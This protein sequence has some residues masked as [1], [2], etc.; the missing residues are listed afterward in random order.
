MHATPIIAPSML[1]CD[2]A[3]MQQEIE[4]LEA[5]GTRWL[6]WDVMDGHFVPNLSYGAMVIRSIRS[7]TTSFFD[8]HLMISDPATY[9]DDYLQAGC[10]A[11]TFHIEAVPE[12]TDLLHRIRSAGRLAGLAINPGT[13]IS[14]IEPFLP[15]CNLILIMSVQPGFGG[16]KFMP[17]VLEKARLLKPKLAP[18]TL[19]SID[20]GIAA[21][22]IASAAAAGCQVFVAGSAIFD[23]ADYTSAV[24]NLERLAGRV[25]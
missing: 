13:P 15:D 5:A 16:Q 4:R 2:Y 7:R 14:A 11:I 20:G 21:D 9:L 1:K 19:L 24:Q 3:N 6:H 12:P 8:A 17:E 23:E 25:D 22:T 18:G 10:D